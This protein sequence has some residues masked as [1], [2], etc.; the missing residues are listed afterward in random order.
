MA[1]IFAVWIPHLTA[2]EIKLFPASEVYHQDTAIL[3]ERLGLKGQ[4]LKVED[5]D[6]ERLEDWLGTNLK[7]GD[8]GTEQSAWAGHRASASSNSGEFEIRLPK[9]RFF[10]VGLGDNDGGNERVSVN[11]NP[12]VQLQR[13]PGHEGNGIGRAFYLLV[14]AEPNDPD[15]RSVV[16]DHWKSSLRSSSDRG[17]GQDRLKECHSHACRNCPRNRSTEKT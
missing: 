6:D 2:F 12:R 7:A 9:V 10:G 11:G 5:F 3:H 16:V 1:F 14:A 8:D 13:L 17:A 4:A 15:I